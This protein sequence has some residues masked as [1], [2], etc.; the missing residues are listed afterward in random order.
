MT[1]CR[2]EAKLTQDALADRLGWRRSKIMKIENGLRRFFFA[3]LIV[4]GGALNLSPQELLA[5]V[6]YS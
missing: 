6:L 1:A 4:I 3:E 2:L 5:R